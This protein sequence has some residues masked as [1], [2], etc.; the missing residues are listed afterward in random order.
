MRPAGAP[1]SLANFLTGTAKQVPLLDFQSTLIAP[2]PTARH[3]NELE[4]RA[5]DLRNIVCPVPCNTGVPMPDG[6][7]TVH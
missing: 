2:D 1:S 6:V 5:A 7:H 4:R 3:F